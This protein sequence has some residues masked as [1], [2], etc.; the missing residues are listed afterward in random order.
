LEMDQGPSWQK[1]LSAVR[2]EEREG[3]RRG[4]C[5]AAR[6]T[7]LSRNRTRARAEARLERFM[8][9][10]AEILTLEHE[11]RERFGCRV[12][13]L[14]EKVVEGAFNDGL[15]FRFDVVTCELLEDPPQR[16]Y[17]WIDRDYLGSPKPIVVMEGGSVIGPTSAVLKRV[18]APIIRI[19]PPDGVP[20]RQ[21]ATG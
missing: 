21:P 15:T 9:S 12:R 7:N 20:E 2:R 10:P 11:V 14:G 5:E 18:G 17:A 19:Y 8:L 13:V 1:R 4:T 3:C 6:M 16:C